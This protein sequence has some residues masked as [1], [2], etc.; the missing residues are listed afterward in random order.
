MRRYQEKK[1]RTALNN[2]D[3]AKMIASDIEG[4]DLVWQNPD[5]EED[6]EKVGNIVRLFKKSPPKYKIV[7]IQ[8]KKYFPKLTWVIHNLWVQNNTTKVYL[9]KEIKQR[10]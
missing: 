5:F 3:Y 8:K 4:C 1:E 2:I 6:D 10:R 9:L 7:S